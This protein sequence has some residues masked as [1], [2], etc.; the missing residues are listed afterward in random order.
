[1][2]KEVHSKHISNKEYDRRD[3]HKRD[4]QAVDELDDWVENVLKEA[5]PNYKDPEL[6]FEREESKPTQTN[7]KDQKKDA[8][9]T[10]KK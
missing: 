7:V 10:G 5:N 6:F 3:Q 4:K 8:K 9:K 2:L 1:M